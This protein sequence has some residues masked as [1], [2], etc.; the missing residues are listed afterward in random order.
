MSWTARDE[1]LEKLY[2][3]RREIE[4]ALMGTP[5]LQCYYRNKCDYAHDYED[6]ELCA[7][8]GQEEAWELIGE[9]V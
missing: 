9:E 4:E 3:E 2:E 8:D 1:Y 7:Y 5:C 6:C